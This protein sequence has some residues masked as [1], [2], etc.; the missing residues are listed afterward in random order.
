MKKNILTIVIM[1]LCIINLVMTAVLIFT[2]VPTSKK[3]DALISQVASV[4]KLELTDYSEE[5]YNVEDLVNHKIEE[6]LTKNL[7]IGADGESHFAVLDYVT[8]SLNKKSEDYNTLS[9][10]ITD[11]DSKIMDIVGTALTQ[12]TY[13]EA[14]SDQTKIKSDILKQLRSYLGSSDFIVDVYFGNFVCQ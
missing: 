14:I 13:D 8:V 5:T 4:I 2:I 6:K 9:A 12:Y 3:T 7:K 1:A 11:Q 10:I